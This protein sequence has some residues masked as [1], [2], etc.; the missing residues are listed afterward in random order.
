MDLSI[1]LNLSYINFIVGQVVTYLLLHNVLIYPL[2]Y[3]LRDMNFEKV[4]EMSHLNSS[5]TT[6]ILTLHRLTGLIL[7]AICKL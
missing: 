4:E 5:P 3:S 2:H 1:E 6:Q 7:I